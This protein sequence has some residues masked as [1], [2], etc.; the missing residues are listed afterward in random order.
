M[1]LVCA[2]PVLWTIPGLTEWPLTAIGGICAA[3]VFI[4][5]PGDTAGVQEN[6][7]S[8]EGYRD[9]AKAVSC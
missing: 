1:A 3:A 8:T 9:R 4:N 5:I 7:T 2:V 6:E